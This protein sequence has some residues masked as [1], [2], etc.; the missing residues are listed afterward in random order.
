VFEDC[1]GP[2]HFAVAQACANVAVLHVGQR[3]DVPAIWRRL[4]RAGAGQPGNFYPHWTLANVGGTCRWEVGQMTNGNS[5]GGTAQ[6]GSPSAW[7]FANLES[8]IM[9]NPGCA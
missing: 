1:Y 3:D 9:K 8:P 4:R 5:F 7:F 6:Y 2:D